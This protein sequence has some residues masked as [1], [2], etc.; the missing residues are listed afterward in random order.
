FWRTKP[1]SE[2]CETIYGPHGSFLIFSSSYFDAGGF[3]DDGFFL[4]AEEFSVAEIC[5]RL[6][7]RVVYDPDLRVWYYGHR[8]TGRRLNRS[9]FEHTKLGLHYALTKY[10]HEANPVKRTQLMG[11]HHAA[12]LGF[13]AHALEPVVQTP[14]SEFLQEEE[15]MDSQ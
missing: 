12:L 13:G 2:N 7:L 4:Y 15:S 10:L 14:K 11:K 9:T 5:L 3:I 8:T 6:C 1:Q